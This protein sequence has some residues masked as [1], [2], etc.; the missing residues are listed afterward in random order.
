MLELYETIEKNEFRSL[1]SKLTVKGD[2]TDLPQKRRD[3]LLKLS[4]EL[5]HH[6]CC[7]ILLKIGAFVDCKND[8]DETPLHLSAWNGHDQCL[9]L[10]LEQ[11]ASPNLRNVNGWTP[12]QYTVYKCHEKCVRTFLSTEK[13]DPSCLRDFG[14]IVQLSELT[15]DKKNW[16][17]Q[18]ISSICDDEKE[19]LPNQ[20]IKENISLDFDEASFEEVEAGDNVVHELLLNRERLLANRLFESD[21]GSDSLSGP[22]GFASSSSNT[23]S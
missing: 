7:D 6:E 11:G 15:R 13:V 21:S 22:L 19:K 12:L 8:Y 16:C 23:T 17:L 20:D 10:L 18:V 9:K 3:W 4:A 14:E 5:G 2:E 1:R